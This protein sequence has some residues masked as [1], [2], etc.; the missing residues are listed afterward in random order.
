MK[1]EITKKLKEHDKLFAKIDKRFDG[2]DKRFDE[3][4]RQLEAIAKSVGKNT[5]DMGDIKQD[6]SGIRKEMATKKDIEKI[7]NTL[8]KLV[9]FAKKKDEEMT[10]MGERVTRVEKDVKHIKPLVGLSN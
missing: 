6:I 9:G 4:D 7:S 8:D 3:H 5:Q 1:N 2:H 10:F